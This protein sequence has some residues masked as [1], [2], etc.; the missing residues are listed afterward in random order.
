VFVL[1]GE[2]VGAVRD[3][4]SP[5]VVLMQFRPNPGSSLMRGGSRKEK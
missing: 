4:G 1:F 2:F 5:L 3:I